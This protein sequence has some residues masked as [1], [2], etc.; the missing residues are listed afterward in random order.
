VGEATM[1]FFVFEK[2]ESAENTLLRKTDK[3][4]KLAGYNLLHQAWE[5][6]G[7][8]RDE[9]WYVTREEL[10]RLRFPNETADSKRLI[11][12]FD[13]SADWR[14][15]LIEPTVIYAFSYGGDNQ[16]ISWTP[17]MIKFRD[18]FYSDNYET[19][20]TPEKK[21]EILAA[22]RPFDEDKESIEFLYLNGDSRGWNWGKNGMTNAAFLYDGAREYF[23]KFF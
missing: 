15:G 16:S 6:R 11:I 12:D 17:L 2:Y 10:V 21:T 3:T 20:L 19:P 1:G 5:A 13:P 8:P 22:V 14:I 7:K 9:G 4:F 18:V 23:R